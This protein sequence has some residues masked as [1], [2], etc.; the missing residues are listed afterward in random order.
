MMLFRRVPPAREQALGP[1]Q[2]ALL[3]KL[4]GLLQAA[5]GGFTQDRLFYLVGEDYAVWTDACTATLA[6]RIEAAAPPGLTIRLRYF[7]MAPLGCLSLECLPAQIA[8]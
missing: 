3:T 8:A 5:S 1:K 7:R 6:R 2:E 4:Y